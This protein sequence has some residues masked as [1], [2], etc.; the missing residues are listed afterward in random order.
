YWTLYDP[1]NSAISSVAL[2]ADFQVTLPYGGNYVLQLVAG[3]TI[4]NYSNQVS[5][6]AFATNTL[7]LGTAI[8]NTIVNPGDQISYTFTG[9]AGQRLYYD[10]LTP[11]YLQINATLFSPSGTVVASGNASVDF[12]PVTL[13][14]AGT[15][16]LLFGGA[17]DTAGGINFQ[18][19]DAGIQP[20]LPLNT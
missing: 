17:G 13:P 18:M 7:A 15:Y 10:A 11:V 5:T 8:T 1:K 6:F 20:A 16:T 3:A 9:T 14:E 19:L 12:G 4:I 2:G